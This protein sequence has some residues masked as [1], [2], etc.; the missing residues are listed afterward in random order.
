MRHRRQLNNSNK[1]SGLTM[2]E[3]EQRRDNAGTAAGQARSAA[4]LPDRQTLPARNET[5]SFWSRL[6]DWCKPSH[7]KSPS[8]PAPDNT[9]P[10]EEK[11]PG[12]LCAPPLRV[13]P[14]LEPRIKFWEEVFT[15]FSRR[16]ALFIDGAHPW[17]VFGSASYSETTNGSQA[18]LME[19][20]TAQISRILE[21]FGKGKQPS[22]GP[23]EKELRTG[24]VKAE[25]RERD[26]FEKRLKRDRAALESELKREKKQRKL[27]PASEK[28]RRAEARKEE[29]QKRAAF[30]SERKTASSRFEQDLK[31]QSADFADFARRVHAVAEKQ[32]EAQL[33]RLQSTLKH[34]VAG[35]Q[36]RNIFEKSAAEKY[37]AQ[38]TKRNAEL[39]A[40][41]RANELTQYCK[42]AAKNVRYQTGRSADFEIAWKR[43]KP[44]LPKIESILRKEC[45][46]QELA[47]IPFAE[48]SFDCAAKSHA[49]AV[50]LW[51]IMSGTGRPFLRIGP[52]IDERYDPVVSSRAAARILNQ[53][54]TVANNGEALKSWPLVATGYN[55]G[56][57]RMRNAVSE[58]RSR[59]LADIIENYRDKNFRY[60]GQNYVAEIIAF[61]RICSQRY[62]DRQNGANDSPW[63]SF[64]EIQLGRQTSLSTATEI[65]GAKLKDFLELNPSVRYT[66]PPHPAPSKRKHAKPA[67]APSLPEGFILRIPTERVAL[68][69]RALPG[70]ARRPGEWEKP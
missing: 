63:S 60:D 64:A 18:A 42:E 24:F 25:K 13:D 17:V 53:M 3:Q 40:G 20:Q 5:S 59:N 65:F 33:A 31:K 61:H 32:V 12:F 43:A 57:Q 50:G 39:P 41:L 19:R 37:R 6:L 67:P 16:D 10:K 11:R 2:P 23:I 28:Q 15:K 47:A 7:E 56:D 9:A 46:P 55:T 35:G 68:A 49:K 27:P 54:Y 70:S 36:P 22:F 30:T 58:L 4:H 8:R 29:A 21:D 26:A 34:L 66:E 45:I 52:K 14:E 48:S 38:I 62:H 44:L 69:L 51:Q 1:Q